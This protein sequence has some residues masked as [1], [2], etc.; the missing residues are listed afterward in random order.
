MDVGR[1]VRA[2]YEATPFPA[3]DAGEDAASLAAKARRGRYAAALDAAISAGAR[4]LDAG[5]GTGQLAC[6]LSMARRT[7]VGLDFSRASLRLGAGFASRAR[8]GASFVQADLFRPPLARASFDVVLANGV[9]HHTAD[10]AGGLRALAALVRPG[11]HLVAGLYHPLGRV[12]TRLRRVLG[13]SGAD[14]VAASRDAE[15]R[16]AWIADQYTH[17]HETSHSVGEALAWLAAA[18]LD[19]VRTIPSLDGDAGG[20]PFQR[21]PPVSRLRRAL[22]ESSWIV[23]LAPEGGYYLAIGRRPE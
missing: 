15:R 23:R 7:V 8:L 17:P 21:D 16:D 1:R 9:L 14:P 13:R 4:V 22:T 10:P 3:Y 2:F 11:G 12:A 6:F 20:S 18:G 19:F 5:C